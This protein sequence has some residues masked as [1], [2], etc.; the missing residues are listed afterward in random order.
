MFKYVT[1]SQHWPA[2]LFPGSDGRQAEA[3]PS[4]P[5]REVGLSYQWDGGGVPAARAEHAPEEY[6][7]TT[8]TA[9]IYSINS[10]ARASMMRGRL[11][12]STLAVLT[13]M[14]S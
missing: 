3:R 2:A 14:T 6:L 13:L 1:G 12:P 7:G 5:I 8:P 11:R 9:G 4:L 10:S